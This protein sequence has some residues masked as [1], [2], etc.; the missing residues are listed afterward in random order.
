MLASR[1]LNAEPPALDAGL[2]SD[3][4]ERRPDIAEAEREMAVANA[5]I[6]V[7][8][9]GVLSFAEF[10]WARRVAGGG[11]HAKLANVSS[12]FWALGANVAE[13]DFHGRRAAGAGAVSRRPA[14]MRTWRRYRQTVL[15]AFQEVQD[16]LTGLSVLNEARES[17]Q[18]AVDAARRALDISTSRYS[19]GLVNY[20]DVVTAQQ[21]LL[22][23]R[24]ATGDRFKGSDW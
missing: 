10:V 21:N 8:T 19:G 18:Q 2:P 3:L 17:Q 12:I 4:L 7:A 20:L 14:T 23:G 15:S 5:Q 22:V 6:G 11:H 16:D 13:A 1:E 9:R 24:A